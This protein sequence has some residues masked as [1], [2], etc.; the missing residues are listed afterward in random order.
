M[1]R[2]QYTLVIELHDHRVGEQAAAATGAEARTQQEVAIAVQREAGDSRGSDGTQRLADLL[3]AGSLVVVADPGLEQIT[4]DVERLR[5]ARVGLEE[6][7]ELIGR[8][9]RARIE[10]HVRDE[11]SRHR[12]LR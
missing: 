12:S 6:L 2:Q 3:V 9:R 11:Q 5:G 7:E 10:M 4:E 1:L 8:L